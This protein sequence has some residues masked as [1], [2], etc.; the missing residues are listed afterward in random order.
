MQTGFQY[1]GDQHKT[2]YYNAQGQMLY[3]QQHLNGHW[4]LFDTVTFLMKT[5]FQYIANQHKIVYY[6]NNG[7]MLYGFQKIKGKTYH[8]NTQIGARI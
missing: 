6:N 1:I 8:F 4:Y 7:Q 2:V 5:G 3:G